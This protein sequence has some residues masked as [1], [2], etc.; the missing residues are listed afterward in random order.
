MRVT[1]ISA[2]GRVIVQRSW[3]VRWRALP[4]STEMSFR[5][6]LASERVEAETE[7][8]K[9]IEREADPA[10]VLIVQ[11]AA[12]LSGVVVLSTRTLSTCRAVR[13]SW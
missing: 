3:C 11:N 1:R 8:P 7:V 2:A 13:M 6:V 12:D 10:A 4:H 5:T 9:P